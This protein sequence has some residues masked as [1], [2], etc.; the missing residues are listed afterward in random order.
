MKLRQI[1]FL[2]R[3]SEPRIGWLLLVIGAVALAAALWIDAQWK[4]ERNE[5]KRI[6]AVAA[7]QC[8][9]PMP[10]RPAALTP[11]EL[12]AQ[13]VQDELR[14]PWLPVLRAVES[15]TI[16]PVYLLALNIDP[17]T[18]TVKMEAEAPSF[19]HALAFVQVLD[20][21]GA[22]KPANL[23]SHGGSASVPGEKP[24]VLFSVATQWNT[25]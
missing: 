18:G 21:G 2:Y 9:K 13:Q 17:V 8:F 25:P 16:A 15:A 19:D 5:A 3:P 7:S 14:K 10:A 24:W 22:L 1:D 23:L 6:Q 11:T 20:A 12:R 4:I